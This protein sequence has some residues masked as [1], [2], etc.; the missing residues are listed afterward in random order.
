MSKYTSDELKQIGE[1]LE[2]SKEMMHMCYPKDGKMHYLNPAVGMM[3]GI[4]IGM[5]IGMLMQ[6]EMEYIAEMKNKQLKVDCIEV[7]DE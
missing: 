6:C 5:V 4:S 2:L 1:M 7:K 3:S